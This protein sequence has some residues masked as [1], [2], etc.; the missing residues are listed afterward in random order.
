MDRVLIRPFEPKEEKTA[1]G[2]IIAETVADK[3]EWNFGEV[4]E[5]GT[6][7]P[8]TLEGTTV[9]YPNY[10]GMTI[11][12]EEGEYLILRYHEIIGILS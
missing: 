1:G 5:I 4:I 2:I 7:V 11:E 10:A 8:V 6:D 12:L 3:R 9:M